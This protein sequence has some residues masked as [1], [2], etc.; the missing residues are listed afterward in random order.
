MR[1]DVTQRACISPDM[2]RMII[3]DK[4]KESNIYSLTGNYWNNN[5]PYSVT[6]FMF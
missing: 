3:I 4:G 5:V 6:N 2:K 1:E